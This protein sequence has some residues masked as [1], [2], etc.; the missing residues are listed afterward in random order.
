MP[1]WVLSEKYLTEIHPI[2]LYWFQ[3]LAFD[4]TD[5]YERRLLV[6]KYPNDEVASLEIEAFMDSSYK[7]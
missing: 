1:Y 2:G 3:N 7:I 4:A 6:G 5:A